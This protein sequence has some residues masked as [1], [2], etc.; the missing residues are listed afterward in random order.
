MSVRVCGVCVC[1]REGGVLPVLQHRLTVVHAA[2]G[3]QGKDQGWV[4]FGWVGL[5]WAR[6]GEVG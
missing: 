4:E 5:G 3:L 1:V 2:P 6:L